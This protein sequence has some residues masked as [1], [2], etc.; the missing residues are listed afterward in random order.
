ML[1][2]LCEHQ[3]NIFYLSKEDFLALLPFQDK[4]NWIPNTPDKYHAKN[5][6]K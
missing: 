4:L 5:N 3:R 1:F 6:E 2:Q